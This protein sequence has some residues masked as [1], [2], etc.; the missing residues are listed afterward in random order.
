MEF[1]THVLK[2][3][4]FYNQI[5]ILYPLCGVEPNIENKKT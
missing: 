5:K 4:D 3:K 1:T 2:R